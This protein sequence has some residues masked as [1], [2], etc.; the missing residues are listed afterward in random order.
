M[1]IWLKPG[2]EVPEG[3][4]LVDDHRTG[5]KF[6][7]AGSLGYQADLIPQ[8]LVRKVTLKEVLH[9]GFRTEGVYRDGDVKITV[10]SRVTGM[11]FEREKYQDV[12]AVGPSAEAMLLAYSKFRSGKL[13]P[14]ENWEVKQSKAEPPIAPATEAP[15]EPEPSLHDL[16][17]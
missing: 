8:E 6:F 11:S 2:T 16:R 5:A 13:E 10:Q 9:T 1:F 7:D 3:L 12:F 17:E 4:K 14:T 15:A